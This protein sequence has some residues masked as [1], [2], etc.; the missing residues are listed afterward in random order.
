[1]S[2]VRVVPELMEDAAHG[3]TGIC[4]SIGEASHAAT[5]ATTGIVPAAADEISAAATSLFSKHAQGFQALVA[6]AR[7]F[8]DQFAQNL[9]ASAAAYV[10]ADSP[11]NK[12]EADLIKAFQLSPKLEGEIKADVTK[13][14]LLLEEVRDN[15]PLHYD[16]PRLRQLAVTEEYRVWLRTNI[17]RREL[18]LE[19]TQFP[20][21]LYKKIDFEVKSYTTEPFNIHFHSK[22]TQELIK[23]FDE[24]LR[25]EVKRFQP[26]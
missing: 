21:E 6:R 22:H 13:L 5:A 7:L 20:F 1:M 14:S 9:K 12:I 25:K 18:G 15:D 24:L 17:I 11:I 4:S 2:F 26:H 3:L 10:A 19:P 8:H 23:D 16:R